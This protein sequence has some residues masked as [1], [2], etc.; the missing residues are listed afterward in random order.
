[1]TKQQQQERDEARA[2]LREQLKPGDRVYT[3]LRH[4]A[5]S[6]MTRWIDVYRIADGNPL[7]ITWTVA[8][9]I[10]A[11]YSR[12]REALEVGGCGMDV[13]FEVAYNLGRALYPDGFGCIGDACRSNDHSNG[14]R[15]YTPH[16]HRGP[17]YDGTKESLKHWHKEGGYAFRHEWL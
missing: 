5:R 10:G 4:V 12:K 7:R 15:D 8:R 9:A 14:D 6:G 13:G 11:T 2:N 16:G 3:V 17:R 1:M